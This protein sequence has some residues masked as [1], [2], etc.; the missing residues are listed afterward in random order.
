VT[1]KRQLET[2]ARAAEQSTRQLDAIR[3]V[4]HQVRVGRCVCGVLLKNHFSLSNHFL[5]CASL[6]DRLDRSA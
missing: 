6:R 4:G 3:R 5:P 1:L 2:A